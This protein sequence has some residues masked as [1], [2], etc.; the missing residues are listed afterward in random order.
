MIGLNYLK[1]IPL[2]FAHLYFNESI[3]LIGLLSQY[4]KEGL[5]GRSVAWYN[6][7]YDLVFANADQERSANLWSEQLAEKNEKDDKKDE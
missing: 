7:V 2:I 6:D 4:I 1:Y 3:I 5:D